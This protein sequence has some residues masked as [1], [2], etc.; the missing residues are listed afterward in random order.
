MGEEV[1]D[2]EK[3]ERLIEEWRKYRRGYSVTLADH[4]HLKVQMQ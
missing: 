3:S 2:T 4:T 1:D